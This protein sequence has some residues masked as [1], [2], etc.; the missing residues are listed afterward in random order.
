MKTEHLKTP[1]D[2]DQIFTSLLARSWFIRLAVAGSLIA[3]LWAMI[4]WAVL[5]P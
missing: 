1:A 2:S 3:T 5:L 4:F